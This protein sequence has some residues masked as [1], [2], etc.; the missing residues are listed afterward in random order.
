FHGCGHHGVV[1][2]NR[3]YADPEAGGAQLLEQVRPHR[4]AGLGAEAPR[5]S[6]G[7]VAG[8]CR[9]GHERDGAKEPRRPPVLLHGAAGAERGRPALDGTA[10]DAH[11]PHPVELEPGTGVAGNEPGNQVGP[12]TPVLRLLNDGFH[13]SPGSGLLRE[14]Y[15]GSTGGGDGS[16]ARGDCIAKTRKGRK[17]G[18]ALRCRPPPTLV[19]RF[20]GNCSAQDDLTPGWKTDDTAKRR[21][22]LSRGFSQPSFGFSL[23]SR[24]RDIQGPP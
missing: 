8:Q 7:V 19:W 6:R 11:V 21:S 22:S 24:F 17:G 5:P 15:C 2:A 3:R 4:L 1:D 18:R 20:V 13:E 10:V 16:G 14:R 23:P 12:G 9:E